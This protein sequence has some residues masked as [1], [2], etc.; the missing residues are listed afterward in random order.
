MPVKSNLSSGRR[1]RIGDA[2]ENHGLVLHFAARS[3]QAWR[4]NGH[5]QVHVETVVVLKHGGNVDHFAL[6]IRAA[7]FQIFTFVEAAG[8]QAVNQALHA[9]VGAVQS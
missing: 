2:G 1:D 9:L 3:G 5:D 8:F 4:G 6:G 7:N